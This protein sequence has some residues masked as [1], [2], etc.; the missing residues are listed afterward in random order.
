M[1]RRKLVKRKEYRVAKKPKIPEPY[2]TLMQIAGLKEINSVSEILIALERKI[3]QLPFS[4][5]IVEA[6]E[7][8]AVESKEP[9]EWER[10]ISGEYYYYKGNFVFRSYYKLAI[11]ILKH[12]GKISLAGKIAYKDKVIEYLEK[13]IRAMS[14]EKYNFEAK[15]KKNPNSEYY[16]KKLEALSHLIN[17]YNQALK[18]LKE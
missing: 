9:V 15:L 7:K 5:C 6:M 2:A 12:Y 14:I 4:E 16:R 13:E 8:T 1:V 17:E 18:W 11:I 10:S 3:M